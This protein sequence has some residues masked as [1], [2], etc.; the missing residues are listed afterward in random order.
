MYNH[1]NMVANK[2]TSLSKKTKDKELEQ[3]PEP[4]SQQ[5]AVTSEQ[6]KTKEAPLAEEDEQQHSI[7]DFSSLSKEELQKKVAELHLALAKQSKK[8]RNAPGTEAVHSALRNYHKVI[9]TNQKRLD[10][11]KETNTKSPMISVCTSLVDFGRKV[12]GRFIKDFAEFIPDP[13]KALQAPK[14]NSSGKGGKKKRELKTEEE[15][16]EEEEGQQTS[17]SEPETKK[18]KKSHTKS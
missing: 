17:E 4:I 8:P 18:Q 14:K 3:V 2:K 11:L 6:D 5:Q 10:K 12:E 16:S 7:E 15:S 13:A 1:Y 9:E